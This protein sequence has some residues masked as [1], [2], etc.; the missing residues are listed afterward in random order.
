[1]VRQRL[2][3]LTSFFQRLTGPPGRKP[4]APINLVGEYLNAVEAMAFFHAN[5]RKNDLDAETTYEAA[6]A[7]YDYIA[8]NVYN[9]K[10]LETYALTLDHY[11]A[12]LNKLN[13]PEKASKALAVGEKARGIREKL[14]QFDK[15]YN[16]NT[17]P[18][19]GPVAPTAP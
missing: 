5:V 6:V 16:Q 4:K 15:I 8:N 7:A 10:T 1:M 17:P 12:F 13:K 11:Q 14:G 18:V 9:S 19:Q 3:L 2:E